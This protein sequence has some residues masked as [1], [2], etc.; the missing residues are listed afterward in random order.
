MSDIRPQ[1]H[2]RKTPHGLDTLDVKQLIKLSTSL[3]IKTIDPRRI[4]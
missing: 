3:P 2:Y 4:M 1:Y